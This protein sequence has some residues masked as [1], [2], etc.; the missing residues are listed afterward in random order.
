MRMYGYDPEQQQCVQFIYTGCQGNDNRFDTYEEC[1]DTCYSRNPL[2]QTTAATT[3]GGSITEAPSSCMLPMETGPCRASY[4]MYGYDPARQDCRRFG[5]G[6]CEGNSNRFR[7]YDECRQTCSGVQ[8]RDGEEQ[9][10]A[11]PTTAGP[12]TEAPGSCMLPMETGPCRASFVVYGYDPVG[13]DC[14]RFE[15][16][17]CEGNSNRF[18]TYDECRQTCSGVQPRDGEEQTSAAPTT[19]GPTTEA[20][21][22]CMLPMETGPCRASFVVYGY[23]PVSRDCGR[24]E[25]GGCEGNSNRFRTY[26]ECRRACQNGRMRPGDSQTSLRPEETTVSRILTTEAVHICHQPK[27]IGKCYCLIL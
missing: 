9:S 16:G 13:Q 27:N 14:R 20:P 21:S 25:Y 18:R 7:T 15:Y 23:D 4:I 24:F 19:A 6:G 3:T 26:D 11:A 17:G 22:S 8:P 12:T 10:S 2:P 1:M 5:W